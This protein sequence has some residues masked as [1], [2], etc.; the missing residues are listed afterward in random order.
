MDGTTLGLNSLC[1]A[2]FALLRKLVGREQDSKDIIRNVRMNSTAGVKTEV[3]VHKCLRV[4]VERETLPSAEEKASLRFSISWCSL[5]KRSAIESMSRIKENA[6]RD[7]PRFNR[8]LITAFP[9]LWI[10]KDLDVHA[11]QRIGRV[12]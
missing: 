5:S 7:V 8:D 9:R 10:A 11:K 3:A 1:I 12:D 4:M 2:N 6:R